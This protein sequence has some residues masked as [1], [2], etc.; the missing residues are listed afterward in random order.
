MSTSN[1]GLARTRISNRDVAFYEDNTARQL[2]IMNLVRSITL[3]VT[4]ADVLEQIAGPLAQIGAA[5]FVDE[6]G[7]LHGD[8]AGTAGAL[9][10]QVRPGRSCGSL[11]ID[12]AVL[13]KAFVF[14]QQ[15]G[16]AQRRRHIGQRHP[17]AT[18]HV[19]VGADALQHLAFARQQQG[20]GR[21]PSSAHGSIRGQRHGGRR[22]ERQQ[23]RT[24]AGAQGRPRISHRD[25]QRQNGAR[26]ASDGAPAHAR[27]S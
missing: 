12:P 11:P 25:A 17:L 18:A 22:G 9:V 26:P 16:A 23:R 14:R 13:V 1:G 15:H 6:T 19:G 7:Q 27:P 4:D 20:F 24:D 3:L 5:G 8:G 21:M 2:R 10:P